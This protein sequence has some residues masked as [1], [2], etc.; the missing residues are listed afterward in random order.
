MVYQLQNKNTQN[1]LYAVVS[2]QND[3]NIGST[4]YSLDYA[5]L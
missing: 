3:S 4:K 5:G 1:S 2:S